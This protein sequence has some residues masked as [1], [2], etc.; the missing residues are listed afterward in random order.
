MAENDISWRFQGNKIQY[1]F[2][3]DM[4][5]TVEQPVWTV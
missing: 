1:E 3:N 5:S 2:N 4:S